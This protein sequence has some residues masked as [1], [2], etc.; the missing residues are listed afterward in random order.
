MFIRKHFLSEQV[1]L[2]FAKQQMDEE[3]T[4]EE[5]DRER[6]KSFKTQRSLE[7]PEFSPSAVRL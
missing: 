6:H 4:E 5:V 7:S 1:F 2:D 3:Q